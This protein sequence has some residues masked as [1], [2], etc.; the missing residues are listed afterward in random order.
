MVQRQRR[1]L[2]GSRARAEAVQGQ[3]LRRFKGKG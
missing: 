3:G 2:G 1:R